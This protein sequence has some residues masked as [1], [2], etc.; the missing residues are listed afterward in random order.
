VAGAWYRCRTLV[1][2]AIAFALFAAVAC[3]HS[4]DVNSIALSIRDGETELGQPA[5][6][7][8]GIRPLLASDPF[9]PHCSGVLIAPRLVL[10]AAHCLTESFGDP[11][12]VGFGPDMAAPDE[13]I[14]AVGYRLHD[15]FE[16]PETGH[17][18]ALFVL[19]HEAEAAPADRAS[20]ALS[21]D[22]IG[23]EVRVVGYGSVD[24]QSAPDG[25][26][27]SGSAVI[28]GIGEF[29]FDIAPA[30][31]M[32]CG[33][34]SGGPVFWGETLVGI[35]SYGD[36][37]CT[38]TG[39]NVDV[40]AESAVIDGWVDELA[41]AGSWDAGEEYEN[42]CDSE[43]VTDEDCPM[44][45]QCEPAE[46][47]WVC[48][49]PTLWP[50]QLTGDCDSDED[51]AEGACVREPGGRTRCLAPCAREGFLVGG[52]CSVETAKTGPWW[53][54][55]GMVVLGIWVVRRNLAAALIQVL[56]QLGRRRR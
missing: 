30:P 19:A 45:T 42:L 25:L 38:T 18:L 6:V 4:P 14:D 44:W 53:L 39:T 17:D 1:S 40:G 10:T 2:P 49:F 8:V 23:Q 26:K 48:V 36:L 12:A 34:D 56:R 3:A 50:G 20:S 31:S 7:A 41:A 28:E 11:L 5:T 21:V 32:S 47:R 51:C 15:G 54:P 33:G 43:C 35:T 9:M 16:T 27:R 37:Q 29:S 22:A 52:G 24:G 46:D 55:V 13:L